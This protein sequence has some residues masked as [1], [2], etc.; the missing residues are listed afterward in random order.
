[1]SPGVF[2]GYDYSRADNPTRTAL[3]ANLASLEGATFGV[4]FASGCAAADAVLHL[5][6]AGDHVLSVDDLYGGSY[7]LFEQV[8]RQLGL[9]FSYADFPRAHDLDSLFRDSTKLVWLET[10]TNPLLK[11]CDI[12]QISAAAH[13]RGALVVVDNTFASPYLQNPLAHGADI[14]VHSTTKYLGGH[15][16]LIGGAVLTSNEKVAEQLH[17]I[18]KSVG[19]VPS[20][21]ECFLLLRSTKTLALRVQRQTEN[22]QRIAEYLSERS[23]IQRVIYP[24]L[25]SHPQYALG[26]KQMRAGG[27]I[28]TIELDGGIERSRRFLESVRVFSLAESLGGVESLVDHPAIMTHAS[29]PREKREALGI[30]DGLVRLSIGVEDIDDLIADLQQALDS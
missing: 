5:L 10:P 19:A 8:Y 24:G 25:S 28:V 13:R 3:E 6:S 29:I 7:R 22:A 30:T 26:K 14:V 27:G 2:Q 18:Q 16:D 4:A 17:F 9:D 12:E 1:Q 15:S 21:F 23:D 11:L 20:P